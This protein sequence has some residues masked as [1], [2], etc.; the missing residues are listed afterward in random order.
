MN[1][2][3]LQLISQKSQPSGAFLLYGG[4]LQL[5]EEV[6]LH[7]QSS[8][9]KN[10]IERFYL[11]ELIADRFSQ[12]ESN[13]LFANNDKKYQ[14]IIIDKTLKSSETDSK[15]QGQPLNKLL[16]IIEQVSPPDVLLIVVQ[17][18]ENKTAKTVWFKTLASHTQAINAATLTAKGAIPLVDHWCRQYNI[19]LNGQ[20]KEWLAFQT[21][22]NLF[23]AKQLV[24]KLNF[25][26]ADK[27]VD[28]PTVRK[29]LA[30]G[31]LYDI[32]DLIDAILEKNMPRSLKI[33][34][35]LHAVSTP[36]PVIIWGLSHIICN[37]LYAKNG[38]KTNM[39]GKNLML[40][41]KCAPQYQEK[42][43][44][45]LLRHLSFADKTC[46]G[47]ATSSTDALLQQFVTT[48]ITLGNGGRI[49]HSFLESKP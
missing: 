42:D 47:V 4:E 36:E 22:G 1:L 43:L 48:L 15:K 20:A 6:K 10:S 2:S 29:V 11:N 23:A 27:E 7:L 44:L 5:V 21:E 17:N 9:S 14:E 39:W 16:E 13:S 28:L 12:I 49:Q 30:D 33:L 25:S 46:K 41:K 45:Q 31:A 24:Q 35:V 19:V 8:F 3:P 37:L 32:Y 18:W 40:L 38:E 26:Q 34:K